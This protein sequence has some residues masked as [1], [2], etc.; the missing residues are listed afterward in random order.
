MTTAVHRRR[1]V[2]PVV[3]QLHSS[4]D[5]GR[6][7]ALPPV[8]TLSARPS[9]ENRT[10]C[11]TET[12]VSPYFTR[13]KVVSDYKA[14]GVL[15]LAIL[16]GGHPFVLL[17][18]EPTRTGP[19]GAVRRVMWGDFG[20]HREAID[21]GCPMATASR[22]FAEETLGIFC[23]PLVNMESVGASMRVM[24]E[25]LGSDASFHVTHK[26]RRGAYRMYVAQTPFVDPMFLHLAAQTNLA[27]GAVPGGEKTAF[28][29][30][31]LPD[32]LAAVSEA[33]KRYFLDYDARRRTISGAHYPGG[34]QLH[35]CFATTMR[36]AVAEGLAECV[37]AAQ[38]AAG[39]SSA[40]S[41]IPRPMPATAP[42]SEPVEHH[43]PDHESAALK[44]HDNKKRKRRANHRDVKSTADPL[45]PKHLMYWLSQDGVR[46]SLLSAR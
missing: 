29:W 16:R 19:K 45:G 9:G 41:T 1:M 46:S 44:A 14:A 17:G 3:A 28:A 34:L 35:P 12:R 7:S 27:T 6:E 23:S 20:G 43:H 11:S 5:D 4:D 36:L 38:A 32:L 25:C 33:R 15:P 18:G 13:S 21:D 30:V 37:V 39:A 40:L 24:A 10:E 2:S 31:P 8:N 22:E 26:L 42:P